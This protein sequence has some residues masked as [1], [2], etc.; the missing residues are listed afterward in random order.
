MFLSLSF[1][2]DISTRPLAASWRVCSSLSL[3]VMG[4]LEEGQVK[5]V[6]WDEVQ[7]K[8]RGAHCKKMHTLFYIAGQ[9][10]KVAVMVPVCLCE[11]V[12]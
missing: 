8:V 6:V 9:V 5:C 3:L 2:G 11:P 4:E 10:S 12:I 7:T 1:T